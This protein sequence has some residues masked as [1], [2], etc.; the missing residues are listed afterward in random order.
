VTEPGRRGTGGGSPETG[1]MVGGSPESGPAAHGPTADGRPSRYARPVVPPAR[2]LRA[3]SSEVATHQPMLPREQSERAPAGPR[4]RAVTTLAGLAG[5]PAA[6]AVLAT[7]CLGVALATLAGS[8]SLAVNCWLLTIG[9]LAIW[10]FWRAIARA[11]PTAGATAFD[12]VRFR[13]VEPPSKLHGVIAIEGVLLDAEWSR[14]GVDHRLRPLLRKIAAARLI[15]HHQ[16]DLET[17]SDEARRIMGDELWALVGPDP[18]RSAGFT[19]EPE[20]VAPTVSAEA[21][22]PSTL[23][24]ATGA[25]AGAPTEWTRTRRGRRGIPRTTIRRAIEQLEAL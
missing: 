10:T 20:E 9:G 2:P 1:P 15:E 17:E 13:P 25:P 21:A 24:A 5:P 8:R 11:L 19:A 6:L 23:T 7:I 22:L 4:R 3:D 18:H 12:A 16:V 14:G